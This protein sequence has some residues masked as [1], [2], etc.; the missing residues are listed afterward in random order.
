MS[1]PLLSAAQKEAYASA[2]VE[3]VLL[4]TIE[5]SHP[6]FTQPIYVVLGYEDYTALL[7]DGVTE[8]TFQAFAFAINLPEMSESSAAPEFTLRVDGVTREVLREI[9]AAAESSEK[10]SVTYRTY[11]AADP[12]GPQNTPLPLDLVYIRADVFSIEMRAAMG[13]LANWGFPTE[14][15]TAPRFPGLAA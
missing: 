3:S 2:P 14:D 5:L 8:V 10:V 11:L 15:Y 7:E 13:N 12:S 9:D 6:D 4:D 1:D